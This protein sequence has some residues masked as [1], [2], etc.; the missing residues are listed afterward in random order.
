MLLQKIQAKRQPF[1][2]LRWVWLFL[3]L[4]FRG[5]TLKGSPLSALQLPGQ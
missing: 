1:L 4:K 5:P 3:T 2:L